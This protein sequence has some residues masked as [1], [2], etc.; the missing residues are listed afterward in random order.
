MTKKG[1]T[2]LKTDGDSVKGPK[3]IK[4]KSSKRRLSIYD[5]FSDENLNDPDFNYSE[6]QFD[7]E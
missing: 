2:P 4:D 7:E 1:I 5:D 6:D 3:L